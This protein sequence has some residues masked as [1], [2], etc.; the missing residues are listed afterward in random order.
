MKWIIDPFRFIQPP[1]FSRG[2]GRFFILYVHPSSDSYYQPTLCRELLEDVMPF[3]GNTQQGFGIVGMLIM[4]VSIIL[5]ILKQPPGPIAK[6]IKLG[7]VDESSARK[8]KSL[9]I[10]RAYL[11]D[12]GLK[13]GV[14]RKT[15]DGRYWVDIGR[16]RR[17]RRR[18]AFLAGM[19]ALMIS[20]AIWYAWPWIGPIPSD[21]SP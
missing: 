4:P 1:E 7:A 5:M 16:N 21:I 3:G 8:L 14:I 2:F 13:R 6:M 11:L 19:L 15:E 12:N 10:P 17:R 9:E 18:L 20:L